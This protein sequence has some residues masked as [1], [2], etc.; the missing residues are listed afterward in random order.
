MVGEIWC[1]SESLGVAQ[2][3][4]NEAV[5]G[6]WIHSIGRSRTCET[7]LDHGKEYHQPIATVTPS[8]FVL[9]LASDLDRTLSFCPMSDSG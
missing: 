7:G 6:A 8:R 2:R 9:F 3:L 4:V 5:P 1:R